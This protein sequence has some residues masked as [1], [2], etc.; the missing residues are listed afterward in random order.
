MVAARDR[1]GA[2]SVAAGAAQI[3]GV[4]DMRMRK[5]LVT[6]ST[7]L[8]LPVLV[9]MI[10]AS[11]G[12]PSRAMS[13]LGALPRLP[14]GTSARTWKQEIVTL[15]SDGLSDNEPTTGNGILAVAINSRGRA[16]G[17]ASQEPRDMLGSADNQSMQLYIGS[18]N[19]WEFVNVTKDYIPKYYPNATMQPP[20][21]GRRVALGGLTIHTASLAGFHPSGP[22][23]GA[24]FYAEE[25]VATGELFAR[26]SYPAGA[27]EVTVSIERNTSTVLT[28]C[29]W[30]PKSSAKSAIID[31]ST[32]VP[33]GRPTHAT[34]A[35]KGSIGI[36]SRGAVERSLVKS[37]PMAIVGALATTLLPSDGAQLLGSASA[38]S[39][40]NDSEGSQVR[41]RIRILA[42]T[43][44][45]FATTYSD[46]ILATNPTDTVEASAAALLSEDEGMTWRQ[47]RKRSAEFW[48]NYWSTAN[49]S[50]P[51]HPNIEYIWTT[52]NFML[53]RDSSHRR[54]VA[55][56]GLFGPMVTTDKS[57]WGGDYT[58]DFDFEKQY[59]GTAGSNHGELVA[60]FFAN[61]LQFKSSASQ[62]AQHLIRSSKADG[63]LPAGCDARIAAKALHFPCHIAPWGMQSR[64]RSVYNHW[65]GELAALIFIQNWEYYRDSDFAR[66]HTYP[67]L[68]GLT[69]FRRCSLTLSKLAT[70]ERGRS[71]D[72]RYD[73]LDD[74]AHEGFIVNNSV[75][76]NSFI[77]RVVRA[78]IEIGAALNITT[79]SYL[80]D[81]LDHL[82]ALPHASVDLN[83]DNSARSE[84]V[85]VWLN[86]SPGPASYQGKVWNVSIEPCLPGNKGWQYAVHCWNLT[87]GRLGGLPSD[88][89]AKYPVWP[90]EIVS[91]ADSPHL[92]ATA[93]ATA[94]A[95]SLPRTLAYG[96]DSVGF[97]AAVLAGTQPSIS[98]TAW[99]AE[100]IVEAMETV[101]G[102]TLANSSSSKG[103]DLHLL[104][105]GNRMGMGMSRA[106]EEMLVSSPGGQYIELFPMWPRTANASFRNLRVKGA[107][108]VSANWSATVK[109]VTL[110]EIEP[111][112]VDSAQQEDCVVK[113][114][115]ELSRVTTVTVA[116]GNGSDNVPVRKGLLT[117]RAKA[118]QRCSLAPSHVP[119]AYYT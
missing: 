38:H 58:L 51:D 66:Q 70:G 117:F 85:N 49:I 119:R 80:Q 107:F 76:A 92:V 5:L 29:S 21:I 106:I 102:Y 115:W 71:S 45:S 95:Y 10:A 16:T 59:F 64:D 112:A 2:T 36:V 8:Y 52:A 86:E 108:R 17:Q 57:L 3:P 77:R 37:S 67:L 110:L 30:L 118:G 105:G 6:R 69:A 12:T 82:V 83:W 65:N 81:I 13:T 44:F 40:A 79:P 68:D 34:V 50:L 98:P 63:T 19:M 94:R 103:V 32:W 90:G 74:S 88:H 27:F 20:G 26:R 60:A 72:Y 4:D 14:G 9:C 109:A 96:R 91:R 114:P 84:H 7:T 1:P 46:S 55:A 42:H 93:Q 53:A 41:H 31:F 28:T 113:C 100:E 15:P 89:L 33:A 101:E 47:L 62:A 23:T 78:Q 43:Q 11:R 54:D 25:R 87:G 97:I 73:I 18:N 24:E 99:T 104:Q 116:C 22:A 35:Q 111:A 48:Q 61:V 56:P 75:I 39:A